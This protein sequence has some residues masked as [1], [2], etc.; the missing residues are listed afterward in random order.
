MASILASNVSYAVNSYH[1]GSKDD[2]SV[3]QNLVTISFGN[4]TLTYPAG[5]IPLSGLSGW[6]FPNV[7]GEVI[8]EDA[9]NGD[10]FLYK[11]DKVNNK[12]RIYESPAVA[13]TPAVA[14]PL[15]EVTTA[16]APAA[17]AIVAQV[18]GH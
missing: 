11:W 3:R 2:N 4:A 15:A 8:I 9:S 10:G 14:A 5:G 12:L 7:V 18:R 13:S 16:F 17:T 6:G 1:Y